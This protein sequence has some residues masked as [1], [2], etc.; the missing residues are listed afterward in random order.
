MAHVS[1]D[2]LKKTY[3]ASTAVS[4]VSLNVA[5]GELIAFLGPSG[6]GKTTTLRMI[7]GFVEPSGGTI[8]IDN[9]DVTRLPPHRRHTGMVFQRYALFPHLSVARNVSFGLEM[10]K[11]PAAERE[12]RIRQAL[13]MVRMWE[14]RERYPRQLSGGQQQ[15][16]AIARALAI[17]PKVFLLDEPLSN[18]DARLRV[19][20]RA[21]IRA[22]QQ[23]LG[24]TTI[25]VTHDQDEA[26]TMADRIAVM[27]DGRIQQIGTA[28]ELYERPANHFVA[29]FLGEMNFF[30]GRT[31][32]NGRFVSE[33]GAPIAAAGLRAGM[34]MVGVR[35]ER[36]ALNVVPAGDENNLPVVVQAMVYRGAWIEVRLATEQGEALVCHL[37]NDRLC[38][39]QRL[40]S[41][42][43][44]FAS[45]RA[46]DCVCFAN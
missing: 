26:L 37:Q 20:V 10:H 25:L 8:R 24:L 19:E 15:R 34:N 44:A 5:D 4:D 3:G 14:L 21:E 40:A 17:E 33:R 9:V 35:P 31:D 30:A 36:V 42:A 2:N 29:H 39:P 23:R 22:L 1:I 43:R 45:F 32:A 16:V 18:L 13:E 7:A 38:T 46:D 6:C 12:R 41:G 27:Y 28:D 11:V